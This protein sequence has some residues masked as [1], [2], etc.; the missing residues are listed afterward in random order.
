MKTLP[1]LKWVFAFLLAS[2]LPVFGRAPG[3]D[4]AEA[5]NNLLASL[6]SEQSAKAVFDWKDGERFNWHFIPRERKGLPLRDMTPPQRHLAQAL[7]ASG[8]SSRGYGK[9]VTIMSLEQILHEMENN[10]PHRNPEMYFFS[11]FGKPAANG[12]WGWRVEGHHFSQNF[13]LVEGKEVSSTPSFLGTNPGEVRTGPRKGLRVLAV[14]ED[15]GR[16]LVQSLDDA[17]K[18]TAIYTNKAPAD[19]ITAANRK[20][21]ALTP[22]G[23]AAKDLN[24]AQNETLWSVVEEYVR[25]ARPDVADKELDKIKKAGVEKITF[26][27][28]GETELGKPHY[29]RVQGAT[30]LLEY[31]NTQNNANHAHC[32]WRDLENDFADDLLR[33]HYDQD[34]AK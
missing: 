20:V 15:L 22:A 8:L 19:I 7:L 16:K 24:K 25:R 30:F 34:H 27:W 18:K 13:T 5:A 32:V 4:M 21:T 17:Q 10:A 26:A 9:A 6:T 2:A 14:E 28:A 23:I 1:R 29:Y 11:I 31:D 12:T 33:K 3:E